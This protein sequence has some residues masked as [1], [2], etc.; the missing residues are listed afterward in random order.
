MH[1]VAAVPFVC[2]KA[3]RVSSYNPDISQSR[4]ISSMFHPGHYLHL[5]FLFFLFFIS[6]FA[7][8]DSIHPSLTS[9]VHP[10]GPS[11]SMSK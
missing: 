8:D 9:N 6:S 3:P 4:Y 10:I 1:I 2:F 11:L 5:F 7:A